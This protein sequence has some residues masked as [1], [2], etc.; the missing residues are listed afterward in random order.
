M[1]EGSSSHIR[2]LLKTLRCYFMYLH[3]RAVEVL[4]KHNITL[5]DVRYGCI[6]ARCD[7]LRPNHSR[8]DIQPYLIST[9]VIML[10]YH[11]FLLKKL[12]TKKYN[13]FYLY[14]FD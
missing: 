3:T 7:Y 6:S 14:V 13:H 10:I 2:V 11:L 4:Y 1:V 9:S 12:N 5:V 8:A